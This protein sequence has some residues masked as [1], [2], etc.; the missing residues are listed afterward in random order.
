MEINVDKHF[1]LVKYTH[2]FSVSLP[3]PR[4]VAML[5]KFCIK[6]VQ[7][8]YVNVG[9]RQNVIQKTYAWKNK[10]STEFRFH[11]AQYADFQKILAYDHFDDSMY[12]L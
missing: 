6:F 2:S 9:N 3:S 1:H 10:S 5:L 8:N 7:V 11:I 4:T 12:T